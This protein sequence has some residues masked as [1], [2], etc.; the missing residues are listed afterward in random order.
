MTKQEGNLEISSGQ[1]EIEKKSE[2]SVVKLSSIFDE[3]D[4]ISFPN[5]FIHFFSVGLKCSVF[6]K[7]VQFLTY[8]EIFS[9]CVHGL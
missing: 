8:L 4:K 1:A 3:L 2:N 9:T 7:K 6:T 5:V